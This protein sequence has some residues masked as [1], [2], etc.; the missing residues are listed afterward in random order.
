MAQSISI[1]QRLLTSL[2][3]QDP[4]WDVS[5][6][7][8]VYKIFESFANELAT[9]IN[10]NTLTS[11]SFDVN[12]KSG[13]ALDSFVNIF[14]INR[15]LGTRAVGAVS[16]SLSSPTTTILTVPINTQVYVPGS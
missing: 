13:I 9:A 14:G 6:G 3:A 7:S 11:Y 2:T 16:F 12:S 10:T 8:P 4:T 5:V 1:L 15:R